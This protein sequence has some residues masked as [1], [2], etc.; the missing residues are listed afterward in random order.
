MIYL[1]VYY[2]CCCCYR[3]RNKCFWNVTFITFFFIHLSWHHPHDTWSKL[4]TPICVA[5]CF[6][7]NFDYI[8]LFIYFSHLLPFDSLV[9]FLLLLFYFISFQMICFRG[10]F[11]IYFQTADSILILFRKM[12][13]L[14]TY[15]S[16]FILWLP[17]DIDNTQMLWK[18]NLIQHILF[19]LF[20]R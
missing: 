5:I 14:H 9:F 2:N 17:G 7:F 20:I 19:I 18:Q 15:N 12:M 16:I 8:K 4:H 6:C 13:V 1:H 10:K 11:I 3:E